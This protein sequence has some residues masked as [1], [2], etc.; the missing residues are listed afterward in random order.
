[1]TNKLNAAFH[2]WFIIDEFFVCCQFKG[3]SIFTGLTRPDAWWPLS[4][5]LVTTDMWR[6][7]APRDDWLQGSPHSPHNTRSRSRSHGGEEWGQAPPGP[8][9]V[10]SPLTSLTKCLLRS[11]ITR[12]ILDLHELLQLCT[13]R[14]DW[15]SCKVIF[16]EGVLYL[17]IFWKTLKCKWF[18][19][20]KCLKDISQGLRRLS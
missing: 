8:A 10:R 2:K 11:Q 4:P 16:Y 9:P 15:R 6:G 14:R 1:M 18:N 13:D 5:P 19:T 17:Y 3:R 12:D 7:E 20:V